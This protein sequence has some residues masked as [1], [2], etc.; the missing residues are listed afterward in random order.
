[1]APIDP[2]LIELFLFRQCVRSVGPW[3]A[4]TRTIETSILNAYMQM[5][6]AALYYIYIEVGCRT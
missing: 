3:S 5:V 4:G 2:I 1:M 6:D